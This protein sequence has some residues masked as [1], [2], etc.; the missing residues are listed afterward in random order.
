LYTAAGIVSLV[1]ASLGTLRAIVEPRVVVA[2]PAQPVVVAPPVQPVVVAP[3]AQPVVYSQPVNYAPV[4]QP[5]PQP[6]PRK[7]TINPDG[8]KVIEY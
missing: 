8:T 6:Q 5:Q 2:A 3:P 7:I 4:Q 1:G